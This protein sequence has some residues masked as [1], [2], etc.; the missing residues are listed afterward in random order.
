MVCL[1]VIVNSF[2]IN[3]CSISSL[4]DASHGCILRTSVSS[5]RRDFKGWE[6]SRVAEEINR[7]ILEARKGE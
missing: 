3:P 7:A 2:F 1:I 5:G 4:T 6:C